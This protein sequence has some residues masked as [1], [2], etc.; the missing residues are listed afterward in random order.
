MKEMPISTQ[1]V[2]DAVGETGRSAV[3]SVCMIVCPKISSKGTGFL[4]KNGWIVTNQHVIQGCSIAEIF[5]KTPFGDT[6]TFSKL[7]IDVHRDLALLF[8]SKKL[9][10]GLSL[11]SDYDL[12]VGSVVST[13]GYPL[14]YNGPAPILSVGY[15]AGFAESRVGTKTLKRL[16]VNGA[17]NPGNSGGP[18]FRS[19]DDRVIG[20]VVSK[21]APITKFH[22]SALKALARNQTGVVFTAIDERGNRK[23]FVESQIVADLLFYFRKLT[24]VMIGE[25]TSVSEL[26]NFLNENELHVP[27]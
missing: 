25:A 21:H 4:L 8:P 26:K 27:E 22:E 16:V 13:W 19:N 5:A 23:T 2:L 7:V 9:E 14:G 6:I 1:W 18:L 10:G 15:L 24:Q 11:G 3:N 17:F 20:I 12:P